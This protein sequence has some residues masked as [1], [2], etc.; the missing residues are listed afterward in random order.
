MRGRRLRAKMHSNSVV[1]SD[2]KTMSEGMRAGLINNLRHSFF[3]MRHRVRNPVPGR[4]QPYHHTLPDRYPWLFG[5]AATTLSECEDCRL[6]SFGCS[7]GDEV[8]SLRRYFPDASITGIDFDRGNIARC[9]ARIGDPKTRFVVAASTHEEAAQHYD[10]IFCLAV[11]CH[12]YLTISGARRSDPL[13]RFD[14]FERTVEDFARC[15]NPGGLLVLHTTSFRFCDTR[16]ARAFDTLLEAEPGQM[17]DDVHFGRDNVRL[18][19]ERYRAVVFRKRLT[20]M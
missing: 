8:R 14:D 13:L 18:D 3:S 20:T 1:A 2:M 7:R 4:F 15:L 16:T 12:G 6:L 5:F 9:R 19:G 17:A 10:A 11:L